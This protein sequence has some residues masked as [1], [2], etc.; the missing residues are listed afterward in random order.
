[1]LNGTANPNGKAAT[2][3]FQYGTTTSYGTD[4]FGIALGAGTADVAASYSLAG[5]NKSTTYHYRLVMTNADGTYYGNDQ[6]FTTPASSSPSWHFLRESGTA[7]AFIGGKH[8]ALPSTGYTYFNYYK[9]TDSNVWALYYGGGK[10]NQVALSTGGN[11]DDW[12]TENTTY[13]Q[14]YYKGKDGHV[15]ALWYG[16]G[17]W[18]QLALT[19]TANVAGDLQT[20]SG[21]NYTYYRGTDGNIWVLWYGGGKWNQAALTSSANVAGDVAVDSTYHFAYY[22]GKD[23]QLWVVWYGAGKWNEAKLST[24]ANV[25]GNLVVD[26]GW[27][28]YYQDSSNVQWVVWFTGTAWAQTNL[29]VNPGVVSGTSSLYGHLGLVYTGADG[30]EHYLGNNGSAWAIAPLGPA[31]L[32]MSDT[33]NYKKSEGFIYTRT[34]DGNLGVFNFY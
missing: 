30:A 22:R 13:N 16:G 12:F 6:T 33:P 29:G 19:T 18:N 31:G 23:S 28:T 24:T 1:M 15:Y 27:G 2:G 34:T 10:W 11:V 3:Y 26:P 20:D 7:N 4:T 9:G 8:T 17:K 14:L 32:G 25:A 5:L 21:T